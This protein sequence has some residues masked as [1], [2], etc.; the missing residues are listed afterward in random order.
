MRALQILIVVV[1]LLPSKIW[2][3]P[4]YVS[5]DTNSFTL[6]SKEC[7]AF[8]KRAAQKCNRLTQKIKK[9]TDKSLAKY[10]GLEDKLLQRICAFDE[11]HAESLMRNSLYGF[12]RLEGQIERNSGDDLNHHVS[13]L[14]SLE[15]KFRLN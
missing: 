2:S 5:T 9:T 13:E 7:A 14:D 4:D 1:S 10:V 15:W 3:Q 12:R 6:T 11:R 8:T